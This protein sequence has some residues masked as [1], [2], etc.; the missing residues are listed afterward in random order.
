VL[1]AIDVGNTN[2]KGALFQGQTLLHRLR[3]ETP[4]AATAPVLAQLLAAWLGQHALPST[5]V[6]AVIIASVVPLLTPQ[7]VDA[8]RQT[9]AREPLLVGPELATG[10]VLRGPNPLELGADRLMNALAAWSLAQQ[11]AAAH[12]QAVQGSVV[13]DLG[14]ATK[15]DCVSPAGEFLGGVIA[16]G[17]A[18]SLEALVARA[19]RLR[20]VELQA[21]ATV[22]GRS[23]VECVQS[24]VMHGHASLVDGLIG[25]LRKELGFDCQVIAT[26][27]LAPLIAPLTQTLRRVEPDLTLHGLRLTHARTLLG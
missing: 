6:V 16:P 20:V 24:G 26:G 25:K 12:G 5:E 9:F 1:L 13:V 11:R 21:P 23:T 2:L 4:R 17:V 8:I 19:A 14:T 10:L 27:G 18:T 3:S 15:L 22:L 7:L